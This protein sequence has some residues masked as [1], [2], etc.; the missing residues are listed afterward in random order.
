MLRTTKIKFLSGDLIFVGKNSTINGVSDSITKINGVKFKNMEILNLLIKS[1][2]LIEI[3]SR[4]DFLTL[5]VR[6]V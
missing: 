3:S 2:L 5:G 6:L 1:K 4:A